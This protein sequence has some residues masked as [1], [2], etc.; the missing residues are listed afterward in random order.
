MVGLVVG[1]VLNFS[2]RLLLMMLNNRL[3]MLD[4]GREVELGIVD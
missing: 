1:V 2:V 3:V 4:F